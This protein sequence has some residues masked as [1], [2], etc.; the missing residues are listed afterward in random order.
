M[1]TAY[2]QSPFARRW[3]ATALLI[4]AVCGIAA[5]SSAAT[6]SSTGSTGISSV[7]ASSASSATTSTTALVCTPAKNTTS[8][9][10]GSSGG[11]DPGAGSGTQTNAST[12]GYTLSGGTSSSSGKTYTAAASDES[13]V[14]VSGAG[15]LTGTDP[16]VSTTGSTKSQDESSFY[17]L[18][19]A[20][21]AKA[22]TINITGGS[23]SSAG[24]GA[25]GVF[26]Y[27]SS[28]VVCVSGTTIK[29][30]A[31]GGH[32]LMASGGGTVI[33][34]NVTISTAGANGAA[35]ATD[36][37]G[38]TETV[39][40]GTM[41]TTGADSPGI[42]STGT[43]TVTDATLNAAISEGAV[44]EGSNSITIKDSSLT[45]ASEGVMLYQ[46][47]SGDAQPGTATY[48]MDGGSLVAKGTVK[49]HFAARGGDACY[50]AKT[51]AVITLKNGAKVSSASGN[52]LYATD[53]GNATLKLIGETLT[54]NVVVDG[55][56]TIAASLTSGTTLTGTVT[57]A[58][59]AL[60]S[61]SEWVVTGK[62]TVTTLS[63]AVISGSSITN[64]V[65]NGHNVYYNP[66]LAGN[67][68]LGGNMYTLA[69]GGQLIPTS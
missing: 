28:S 67:S 49:G 14:L 10:S 17:G 16:T 45:G 51:T 5:C 32:G 19:A 69:G 24:T 52:L 21:L 39:T 36:R 58:A 23:I 66:E 29:A 18:N 30:T 55:T 43:I 37:G 50:V 68:A 40:G 48:T 1:S 3:A 34:S 9:S 42:Y 6:G 15:K 44:V 62:S 56:G 35:I 38:G 61:S 8:T 26:A 64:I 13:A 7:A 20:V 4:P 57:G 54:G 25:N 11:G 31:Q 65:G 63:G 60:D 46:S 41:T 12:A 22:G 53:A 47:G 27:G 2:L 33:A 59:V